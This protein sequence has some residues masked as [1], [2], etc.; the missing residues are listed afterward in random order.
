M[1][2]T[3]DDYKA[4]EKSYITRAIADAAKI[5][6]LPSIEAREKVGRR[7]GGDYSGILFPIWMPGDGRIIAER[8]RLDH[9]PVDAAT[10]KAQVRYLSAPGQRNHIYFPLELP[11]YLSDTS[12]P[13]VLTEG[14][15][16][17]LA[18]HRFAAE[19]NGSGKPLF[20]P[21]AFPGVY[22]WRGIVG[23]TTDANGRRVPE[24]GAISDFALVDWRGRKSVI[25]YDTNV[26]TNPMVRAA[27]QGLARYLESEGAQVYFIDLPEGPG[28]NGVDDYLY[29]RGP[30]AFRKLYEG[31]TRYRWHD[32]LIKGD[33]GK[34][35]ASLANTLT[36]LQLAPDWH[37][38][39]GFSEF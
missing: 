33:Q 30:E 10:R 20:L 16:K 11:D 17:Y 27:R 21:M 6:R 18:L 28:I 7:G 37:A 39:I 5:Y 23:I 3:D 1:A 25:C 35:L 38:V 24:K 19:A 31:A 26:H 4:L 32:E 15:K 22:S 12:L 36:A 34:L 9:P 13:V 29:V 14:E 2:L 8:L